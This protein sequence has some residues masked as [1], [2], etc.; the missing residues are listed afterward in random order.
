L[1]G[2]KVLA[3]K[4]GKLCPVGDRFLMG[5]QK[6]RDGAGTEKERI[7]AQRMWLFLFALSRF[8]QPLKT[9]IKLTSVL[10]NRKMVFMVFTAQP[11]PL[12]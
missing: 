4:A 2:R 7:N 9:P 8:S 3:E 11:S 5:E 1:S 12:S 10:R 6:G